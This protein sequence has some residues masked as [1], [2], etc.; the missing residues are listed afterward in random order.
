MYASYMHIN[1]RCGI[2]IIYLN[3]K[4]RDGK[5]ILRRF[6]HICN[7]GFRQFG[8]TLTIRDRQSFFYNLSEDLEIRFNQSY[9]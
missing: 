6:I 1:L 7:R 3:L 2:E 5:P 4:H 8:V 9:T